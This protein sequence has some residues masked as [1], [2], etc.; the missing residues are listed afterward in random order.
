MSNFF[1]FSKH[2]GA[3]FFFSWSVQVWSIVLHTCL[4]YTRVSVN[5]H[6]QNKLLTML[7]RIFVV[8]STMNALNLCKMNAFSKIET[9]CIS[10]GMLECILLKYVC[11]LF[12]YPHMTLFWSYSISRYLCIYFTFEKVGTLETSHKRN[13]D[14]KPPPPPNK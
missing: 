8:C 3:Y 7:E 14:S 6:I 9:F 2:R 5:L 10:S 12:I 13:G 11:E 1:F 4:T